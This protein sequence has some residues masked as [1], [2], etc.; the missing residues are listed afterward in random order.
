MVRRLDIPASKVVD[1]FTA[2]FERGKELNNYNGE[3]INSVMRLTTSL[4]SYNIDLDTSAEVVGKFWRDIEKGRMSVEDLTKSFTMA[5]TSTEGQRAFIGTHILGMNNMD[6]IT[7][8][9]RTELLLQGGAGTDNK[10]LQ[11]KQ[12]IEQGKAM[13]EVFRWAST[14]ADETGGSPEVR[15]FMREKL[16]ASPTN[17]NFSS[18][19]QDLRR[20]V[21]RAFETGEVTP[22]AQRGI[23]MA[24][25]S[26]EANKLYDIGMTLAKIEQGPL[27]R[28]VQLMESIVQTVGLL[29]TALPNWLFGDKQAAERLKN[30]VNY[31]MG[32]TPIES[33]EAYKKAP[34]ILHKIA[35]EA[36]T[37]PEA[38]SRH[39]GSVV[40]RKDDVGPA[41]KRYLENLGIKIEVE[42]GGTVDLD[43]GASVLTTKKMTQKYLEKKDLLGL[44]NISPGLK[45]SSSGTGN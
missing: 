8:M 21:F 14:Q 16:L 6:A 7:A 10:E 27:Q 30:Q 3:Y 9:M 11:R 12:T 31:N 45:A 28:I 29:I 23:T 20:E 33:W 40:S 26:D 17:L 44:T 32:E 25:R 2:L 1:T 19:P 34:S 37:N 13:Q 24:G 22:G 41:V 18:M 35:K 38:A 36:E 43:T 4:R 5:R 39:L 42:V 15:Q